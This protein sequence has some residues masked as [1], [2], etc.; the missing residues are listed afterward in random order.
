MHIRRKLIHCK[1]SAS[2]TSSVANNIAVVTIR[3]N[4]IV[5]INIRYIYRMFYCCEVGLIKNKLIDLQTHYVITRSGINTI[6]LGTFASQEPSVGELRFIAR[7]SKSA[8]PRGIAE[9]EIE[10]GS[11]IEGSDVFRVNGQTRSKFY[12]SVSVVSLCM[13]LTNTYS[14][15]TRLVRSDSWRI[16]FMA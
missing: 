11:A 7:L 8:L 13:L 2:V 12:S 16:K 5:S 14:F 4:T 9:A 15:E 6:Y 1:G 10:G 3:T